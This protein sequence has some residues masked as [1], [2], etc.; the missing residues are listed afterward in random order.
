MVTFSQKELEYLKGQQIGRIATTSKDQIPQ[1]T[2]VA[3]ATD[4]GKVYMNIQY[5]SKKAR[6]IRVNPRI[7]FVVDDCPTWETFR[8][9]LI[10]GKAQLILEGKPH[11]IGRD[12][13]YKKYPKYQKDFSIEEGVW[14]KY[15][16][17]ITPTKI[18]SWGPLD[19]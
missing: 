3:F 19:K 9:V 10:S 18:G 11:Q 13:L 12:L 14:S 15:I 1:V 17:I 5:D 6:N 16:L 8:G 2:P 7:S 4:E